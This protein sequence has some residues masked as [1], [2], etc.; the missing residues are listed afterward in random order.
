MSA[1]EVVLVLAFG[2]LA[3]LDL[4]SWPQ[5]QLSRPLVAGLLGG[6]AVGAPLE[7]VAVG[8]LL[9]LFALETLPVGAVRYPDWGPG[10]VAAGALAGAGPQA[11]IPAG[12]L[13]VGM[14]TALSAWAGGFAMYVVRRANAEALHARADALEAGDARVLGALQRGGLLR[15]AARA[16]ALTAFTLVAGDL[17]TTRFAAAWRAPDVLARGVLAATSVGVALWAAWRLFGHDRALGYFAGGLAAGALLV[18][19]FR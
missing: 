1:G 16:L 18:V 3:G 11:A 15:D 7:G 5:A 10:A 19:G 14:V 2:T 6:L 12:L 8:A 17:V 4:V 13:G 9:E